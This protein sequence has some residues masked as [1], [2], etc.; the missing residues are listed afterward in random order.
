ME[1]AMMFRFGTYALD[2]G[3][4]ELRSGTELVRTEPQVFDILEYLIV[5]RERVITRDDLLAAIWD[6]RVVSESAL[7]TRINAVRK[8][9]GDSGASQHFI[10]TIP[11]RGL[12]FVGE[13]QEDSSSAHPATVNAQRSDKSSS[14]QE[15]RYC[16]STD[17]V[18]LA[19]SIAGRGPRLFKTAN[20]LNHLEYDWESPITSHFL[21][22]LAKNFTLA[23]Y[24]ARGTGL[25]D[26]EVNEVSFDAWVHDL[27]T[28]VDVVEWD[29][30]PLMGMSQGCAVSIA[31]AVRRPE[32]VS[33]LVLYG[34][35]ARGRMAR[36][37]SELDRGKINAIETLVHVG[38][39][40]QNPAFRRIFTSQFVPGGTREQID[41]FNEQQR[42]TTSP[43]CAA[44]YFRTTNDIDVRVLLPQV[45]V[46]TLALHLHD[47]AVIP[48]ELGREIAAGIEAAR[49]VPL[50]GK[51]HMPLAD[52]PAAI[53]VGLPN[54][55]AS[56]ILLERL[57]AQL[58]A[59]GTSRQCV[60]Q[61][62][63]EADTQR[64][65]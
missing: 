54:P 16:R 33:H 52:D 31:Y 32:R 14:P 10:R 58:S 42:R 45:R 2:A 49:F 63:R 34:G 65:N 51:N 43:A 37:T 55:T 22:G 25:S 26:W 30:F 18:R 13:V 41:W 48:F 20:Y 9:I 53:C 35:F 57:L 29:R 1:G 39:G 60:R 21:Q 4:R 46:P 61:N 47:D 59:T 11:R 23:R 19:F 17:G 38:W 7:S 64:C 3:R 6:D 28:I 27:E 5:N 44:R 12:R 15:I 40:E 24:D 50:D 8:A 56:L 36:A 62:P